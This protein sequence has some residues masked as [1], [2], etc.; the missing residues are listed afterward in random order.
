MSTKLNKTKPFQARLGSE[1]RYH[2]VSLDRG[3]EGRVAE[4]GLKVNLAQG[5]MWATQYSPTQY[6]TTD[7]KG[8]L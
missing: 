3:A 4:L 8:A 5:V 2:H 1:T 7:S 6:M